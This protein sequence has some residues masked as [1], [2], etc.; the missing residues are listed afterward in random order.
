[1]KTN[2]K[3]LQTLSFIL[4]MVFSLGAQELNLNFGEPDVSNFPKICVPFSVTDTLNNRISD[5]NADMVSVFEDS[6]NNSTVELETIRGKGENVSVL[7]AVDASG[8]MRGGPIDSV[9]SA[10][11]SFIMQIKEFDQISIL[12]FH[13]EVETIATFTSSIDTLIESTENIAAKGSRTELYYGI[14]TG[15]KM[16]GETENLNDKKILIVLSD[17]K[18]EGEAYT[19]DDCINLANELGIPVYSIG[20]HSSADKKY[21]R[22]LERISDKTGGEYNYSSTTEELKATYSKVFEQIQD[23]TVLCYT[24]S[25]FEAD[26]LEHSVSV[27]VEVN[28]NTGES[29]FTFRS[30]PKASLINNRLI[31]PSIV[32]LVVIVVVIIVFRKKARKK[33]EKEKLEAEKERIEAEK[34]QKQAQDETKVEK[35]KVDDKTKAVER[36]SDPRKTIISGRGDSAPSSIQLHFN[37]GP[38]A[39]QSETISAN[40]T[41]GR[42]SDNDIVLDEKTVSGNH[43]RISVEG[44]GYVIY[45]M[46]ST[47]GT[48]VNGNKVTSMT[49]SSG[50]TIELGSVK[51]S[52]R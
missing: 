5:L 10:M 32:G 7:I 39:G 27:A 42:G 29:S 50:S 15:L 52:V 11:K 3:H 28:G 36:S 22:V 44:T 34:A 37:S 43:C 16:L 8:S 38:L 23:R 40:S 1:M 17:G 30:P 26:S 12:S 25:I 9:K 49:L 35:E 6:V 24:T 46:D 41:I 14:R 48:I 4:V 2:S 51:I 19:D 33:E 47:N 20:F 31:L 45:D 21:L 13:D 18:N